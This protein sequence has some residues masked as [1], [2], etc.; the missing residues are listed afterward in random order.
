MRVHLLRAGRGA[1]R[2]VLGSCEEGRARSR[3]QQPARAA[4][5]GTAGCPPPPR[6]SCTGSRIEVR[7]KRAHY[8]LRRASEQGLKLKA[9]AGPPWALIEKLGTS[10]AEDQQRH[11]LRPLDDVLDRVEQRRLG[12]VD[13]LKDN[14]DWTIRGQRLKELAVREERLLDAG[15]QPRVGEARGSPRQIPLDLFG[16]ART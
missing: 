1:P 10:E 3:L 8:G 16:A 11:A 2:A 13:V 12:P 14:R 15:G 7:R 9:R 5:R 6:C 4:A